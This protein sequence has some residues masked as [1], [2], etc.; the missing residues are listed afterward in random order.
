[1]PPFTA[2]AA[3]PWMWT[4]L[5]L[6]DGLLVVLDLGDDDILDEAE[7][8]LELMEDNNVKIRN[9]GP[10]TFTEKKALCAA[11]KCDLPGAQD[12]LELLQELISEKMD[13]VPCSARTGEGTEKLSSKMFFDVLGKIRVYTHPPGKKTDFTQPV[14]LDKGARVIDAAREIHKEIA[15]RL[16]YARVWGKGVFDGQMVQRDHILHDGDV[17]VFYT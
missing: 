13:V 14:V 17:I 8:L 2:G 3:Q 5:R 4:V 9:E 16:K 12:R 1:M 7:R 11:S 6:S 10:R 15:A